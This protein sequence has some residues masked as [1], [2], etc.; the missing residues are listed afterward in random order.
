MAR[1]RI[2]SITLCLLVS[3]LALV[4]LSGCGIKTREQTDADGP[5]SGTAA[6]QPD[7]SDPTDVEPASP[8]AD[9]SRPADSG[10]DPSDADPSEPV[11][12][13]APSADSEEAGAGGSSKDPEPADDP[14]QQTEDSGMVPG[15]NIEKQPIP[16][17]EALAFVRD[18]KVGWNLGN[19]F[20]A[21][22]ATWL[23]NKLDYEKA[24]VGVKTNEGMIKAVK[25]AGF[26]TI[27][28]PVSWHN[29]VS[30][31]D[32]KIDT[33]WLDRVQEVVDY[34][35]KYDLYIII[36]IHHDMGKDY[37]YTSKE[38]LGQ[39]VHYV[40][41]IWSQLAER[42]R[43]YSHR[44]IF[45]SLNEPRMV[46]H[47]NEWWLDL[48]NKDCRE[49]VECL[50]ELNQV[51]VDTVRSS[52]GNNKDRYLMVPGYAASYAGALADGFAIPKDTVDNR[53]IVSVH[54]YTPYNFALDAGGVRT[55]D[56]NRPAS[57]N[58][59]D[60]F[61]TELYKKFI[62]NG[63]PVVIGEFGARRKGDNLQDRV[64]F[65]AYYVASAS[66][67]GM[68]CIWWDNHGFSGD[69]ELFGLLDRRYLNWKFP[70]IVEAMMKYAQKP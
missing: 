67:R 58:E 51:F 9:D 19:T 12:A 69:G 41:S 56:I 52:G 46:G 62:S 68:T 1:W 14:V 53:I 32:H 37:I 50:N 36:N 18:M 2:R 5:G 49:A 61:M 35:V 57:T 25:D 20:D 29:H 28:I 48:S 55:F 10:S 42:F 21:V 23:T 13:G 33:D 64:D 16:D 8:E 60:Y 40:R 70:E 43:D 27:R 39:S 30:G 4:A 11:D 66:A 65:T 45:E 34:A 47:N 6:E 3:M 63:I 22:D 26:N 54:A 17:N 38:Y 15:I 44:L 31:D 7:G 24:W 59:I